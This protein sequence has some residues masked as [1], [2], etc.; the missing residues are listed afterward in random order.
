[1]VREF[2]LKIAATAA[3]V[4]AKERKTRFFLPRPNQLKSCDVIRGNGKNV[5]PIVQNHPITRHTVVNSRIQEGRRNR[6][7][8]DA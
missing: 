7:K 2:L 8:G 3:S 5:K 1:M 6:L 4:T